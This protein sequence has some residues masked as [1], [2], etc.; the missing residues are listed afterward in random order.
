MSD[1]DTELEQILKELGGDWYHDGQVFDP[2]DDIRNCAEVIKQAF[3]DE[4][5]A[6][7]EPA[8]NMPNHMAGQEFYDK[9]MNE[10]GLTEQFRHPYIDAAKRAAGIE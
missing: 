7:V 1:L 2:S 6:N 3:I 10:T 8:C 9:F 5:W 4:G